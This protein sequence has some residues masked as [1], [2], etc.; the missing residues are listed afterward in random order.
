MQLD[1][2][3]KI[4]HKRN[5]IEN[6][7]FESSVFHPNRAALRVTGED[8]FVFLQNLI[9][10]DLRKLDH[11]PLIYSCF[12]TAQGKFCLDFFVQKLDALTYQLECEAGER[13]DFFYKKLKLYKLRSKI[14]IEIIDSLCVYSAHTQNPEIHFYPDPRLTDPHFFRLYEKP[15]SLPEMN[16][17]T[18]ENFRLRNFLI[19]SAQDAEFE[20]STLVELRL[21]Q[22][23]VSYEKGC[24]LGQELTA[25]MHFRSLGKKRLYGIGFQDPTLIPAPFDDL[26]VAGKNWG[27]MRSSHQSIGLILMKDEDALHLKDTKNDQIYLLGS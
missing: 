11:T 8:S 22:N 14:D 15:K 23:A 24:Y 18:F 20:K 9:T 13:L 4:S 12:L 17:E 5:M 3:S 16:F 7:W 19:D 10:Q 25:R 1:K 6:Q 27:N 21:D 2:K 26:I